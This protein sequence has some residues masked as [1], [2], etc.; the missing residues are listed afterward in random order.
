M[1]KVILSILIFSFTITSVAKSESCFSLFGTTEVMSTVRS[2]AELRMKLDDTKVD[3]NE[4]ILS[5]AMEFA[6]SKKENEAITKLNI[7]RDSLKHIMR[8]EIFKISQEK[9]QEK[10][11][12][13]EH[14][15]LAENQIS[16][17]EKTKIPVFN[18]I[19]LSQLHLAG[20]AHAMMATPV[21]Q[22]FWRKVAEIANRTLKLQLKIETDP[23]LHQGNDLLPL[24]NVSPL[25]VEDW[26]Q[27]LNQL[28]QMDNP[29]IKNIIPDAKKS[30]HYRLP[31]KLE[32]NLIVD[33]FLKTAGPALLDKYSWHSGNANGTTHLVGQL[34][35]IEFQG[36][37][38]YDMIG[39]VSFLTKRGPETGHRQLVGMSYS[40]S[41]I[42]FLDQ[43]M[44]GI[45]LI[46]TPI[47]RPDM[48]FR[49]AYEVREP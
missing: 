46:A 26:I 36:Q 7:S 23:S 24:E 13:A 35:P 11:S 40:S 38:F 20:R 21:T 8:E 10:K 6:Y 28:V 22:G 37:K 48:G 19:T 5:S 44:R 42:S 16:E 43:G 29:E 32:W 49:L 39:N 12:I 3:G 41:I 18:T 14:R 34:D 17:E 31:T 33:S 4:S 2:L 15:K 30:F 47:A 27:A 45:E 9:E 1:R 25:Q